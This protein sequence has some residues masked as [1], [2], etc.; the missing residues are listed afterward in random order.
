MALSAAEIE[1]LIDALAAAPAEVEADNMKVKSHDLTT[2]ITL[3][4]RAAATA[5]TASGTAH[6]GLRFS[7]LSPPGGS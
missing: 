4:D 3:A 7:K 6:A 2:L 5:A 1:A